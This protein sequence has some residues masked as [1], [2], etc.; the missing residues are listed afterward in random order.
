MTISSDHLGGPGEPQRAGGNYALQMDQWH[1][2]QLLHACRSSF[3][4]FVWR[5]F[6]IL[7][8]PRGISFIDNWHV[9][10]MCHEL[11]CVYRGENRRLLITVPP[12]HLK[13]ICTSIGF[14]AWLLG[15]DPSTKVILATYGHDLSRSIFADLRRVME[16][17]VYQA[18][19]PATQI[20]RISG[21]ELVT[22]RG[23]GMKATSVGGAVTGRGADVIIIDDL[24]KAADAQSEPER[25]RAEDFVSGTLLSRFDSKRDGRVVSIQ[26]R[27]HEGDVASYLLSTGEYRHLNLP[28]IAQ[29]PQ[30]IALGKGRV[31]YR[32]VGDVLFPQ[33]EPIEVLNRVRAELGPMVFSAQYLQDPTP[34]GGN[35]MSWGDFHTYEEAPER[36]EFAMVVQS[37]DTGMTALPH[38]DYSVCTTW[39]ALDSNNWFLLDVFRQRLDY[40][41]LKRRVIQLRNRWN[42]DRVIIERANTG[43]VLIRELTRE[44]AFRGAPVGYTPRLDK[45]IRFETQIARLKDVNFHMPEQA[46][47]LA[48]FRRECLAFPNGRHDDQVDSMT[49]FL[50]L[51]FGWRLGRAFT[52]PYPGRSARR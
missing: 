18:L 38:S 42:A 9:E 24:M 1:A 36:T 20:A 11:E 49:Q 46:D 16:H 40:G 6:D 3:H 45:Q 10:A 50:D 33:Q 15:H 27:L 51:M 7:H 12:R 14:T 28:A 41:D 52:D 44:N 35:R 39:G 43:I 17:P 31:K 47:W 29:E 37:W 22:T 5:I 8:E 21:S 32:A 26:Q 25:R 30:E 2:Q 4:L 48:D 19:F 34:P 23:G 13:T